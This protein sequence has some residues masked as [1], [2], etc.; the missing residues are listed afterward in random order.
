MASHPPLW[1]VM[2]EA[3]TRLLQTERQTS[4]S[5]DDASFEAA[6][7]RAI[8]DWLVPAG[9]KALLWP[10]GDAGSYHCWRE[11]QRIRDVLSAEA[12]LADQSQAALDQ[13]W[14]HVSY[15]ADSIH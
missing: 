10:A 15:R 4:E 9:D 2:D 11:R 3:E 5:F 7:I 12:D 1:R 13:E 8:R 6:R 14:H